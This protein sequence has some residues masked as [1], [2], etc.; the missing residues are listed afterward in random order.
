MTGLGLHQPTNRSSS[1]KWSITS[2]TWP[3]SRSNAQGR[4]RSWHIWLRTSGLGSSERAWS[5]SLTS[6]CSRCWF[7]QHACSDRESK[8]RFSKHIQSSGLVR[9]NTNSSSSE[10]DGQTLGGRCNHIGALGNGTGAAA[11]VCAAANGTNAGG[12]YPLGGSRR[13]WVAECPRG[14]RPALAS[15]L[16]LFGSP[17]GSRPRGALS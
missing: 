7:P 6:T 4:E 8:D 5:A 1:T 3:S 10:S 13:A 2:R 17:S 14:Q 15:L 11:S 12:A 16:S 9:T